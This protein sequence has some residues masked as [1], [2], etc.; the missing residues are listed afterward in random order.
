[1]VTDIQETDVLQDVEQQEAALSKGVS[2]GRPKLRTGE[3]S[4]EGQSLSIG[5]QPPIPVQRPSCGKTGPHREREINSSSPAPFGPL[6][7][8]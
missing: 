4:G 8:S 2:T 3:A 1:M 6:P 7:A 5:H